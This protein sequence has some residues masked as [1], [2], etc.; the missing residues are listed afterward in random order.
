[1][2][3]RSLCALGRLFPD[4]LGQLHEQEYVDELRGHLE[5]ELFQ[6]EIT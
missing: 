5:Y 1:M 3:L 6:L 4:R 2:S